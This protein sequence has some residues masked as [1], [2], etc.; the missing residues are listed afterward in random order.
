MK[1][2]L[3]II[4]AL[5]LLV[6]AAHF[7]AL[8]A[9]FA[10]DDNALVL[11]DPLIRSWRLIP[12]G[13]QHFLFTDATVSNFYRP[14]QR[15]TYTA[16]YAAVGFRAQA[17]HFTNIC[18]HAAATVAFFLFALA[19]LDLYGISNRTALAVVG[20]ASAAW[21]LHSVHSAAID[22]VSGRADSL[23]ALFGFMALSFALCALRRERGVSAAEDGRQL[24]GDGLEAWKC[25]GLSA[26]ALL[27]SALSK[28]SGLI[29]AG[30][31]L[32]LIALRKDRRAILSL[33]LV[34]AFVVTIYW[35]LRSQA[36]GAEVPRLTPPA[37]ALV[38]PIIAA[39]ALAEYAALLIAPL[40][41]HMERDVE[42]HP[43]GMDEASLNATA[44][45]ELETVAGVAL[46]GALLFWLWRARKREP[47]V[48]ALLVC[49]AV[50]YAPVCGLFA[51]N[52]TMA[53]HWIYVPSAFVLLAAAVQLSRF[54]RTP[55]TRSFAAVLA[56]IWIALLGARSFHRARDWK[57]ER[58]FFENTVAQGGDSARML[59]NLG[60]LEMN[61]GHLD[62]AQTLL[63]RALA[64]QPEQPFALLNR[65]RVALKRNDFA[66]AR[67][68]L[69]RAKKHAVTEAQTYETMAVLE[70]KESGKVDLLRL[71]LASRTGTPSWS[72][73]QRYIHALDESGN[74]GA[75]MAELRGVL[76]TEPYRA[77]SWQLLSEYLAKLGRAAQATEAL[78]EARRLDVRLGAH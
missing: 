46:A 45:R 62:K 78:A 66:T 2:R 20:I 7:P 13:L 52:A 24:Q 64:K 72:I 43:W 25:Y 61:E 56:L 4:A 8:N 40:H 42:S 39:R 55:L 38:R 59:I 30:A 73:T 70:F 12:E 74:T 22:Y 53:E 17:Y 10:W 34:V 27:A 31:C 26:I 51:L 48:F 63:E 54:L 15:L 67:S 37:P 68:F 75:A 29:F 77:E 58:T 18:L 11:R 23:A 47:A 33:L 28:E 16:E 50:T 49:A 1:R 19:L 60:T 3:I 41:L 44:G 9:G 32:A 71:R 14:V 76:A 57:N 21:A 36:T 65:A 5:V 35:T 6:F 69:E